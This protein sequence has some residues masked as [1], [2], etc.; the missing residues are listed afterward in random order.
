MLSLELM[1]FGARDDD[2]VRDNQFVFSSSI[3]S[4]F[5][6]KSESGVI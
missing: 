6:L 2:M 4:S 3:I 1:N 5:G